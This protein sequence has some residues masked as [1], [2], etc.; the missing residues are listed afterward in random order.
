MTKT[1]A[2]RAWLTWQRSLSYLGIPPEGPPSVRNVAWDV[3]LILTVLNR[4]SSTPKILSLVRT[5]CTKRNIQ[6][7]VSLGGLR[8]GFGVWVL[9]S[10]FRVWGLGF[11]VEGFLGNPVG[12][13]L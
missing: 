2:S 4:D 7:A 13:P 9:C 1:P 8:S 10:G 11:R 5:V 6:K 3:P 12:V